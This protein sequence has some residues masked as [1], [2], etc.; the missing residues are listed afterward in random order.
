MEYSLYVEGLSK[1][2]QTFKLDN[3]SFKLPKGSIMGFVGENGSGKTTT[4]KLILNMLKKESGD[5]CVFGNDHIREKTEIKKNIG[6]ILADGF[7]PDALTL[8]QICK[9]M[10]SLYTDFD[11]EKFD[12]YVREFK[13]S[14][15][16]SI[17]EFST[18]MKMKAKL[19]IV[20]SYDPKL[21]ILDEPTNGLD[22]VARAEV[23]DI[24]MEYIQDEEKSI[25]LSSHIT[26]DLEKIAD[27][28][29]F[30]HDGKIVFS[31]SREFL[32]DYY[33]ILKCAKSELE[34]IDR[35]D[36]ISKRVNRFGYELLIK[37]RQKIRD[38]YPEK[39][40]DPC[41]YRRYY[42]LLR[43]RRKVM[44]G[45]LLKEFY[46]LRSYMKTVGT[47]ILFVSVI[48]FFS[49]DMS[50]T[51][52]ITVVWITMISVTTFSIDHNVG[53]NQ[54]S[55]TLPISTNII[56]LSKYVLSAIL[57]GLGG[58]ISILLNV[59]I[60]IIR[61]GYISIEMFYA[62][63]GICAVALLMIAVLLPLIYKYGVE[64]VRIMMLFVFVIPFGIFMLLSWLNVPLPSKETISLLLK[65]SPVF[66]LACL[67]ISY[68]ISCGIFQRK[69]F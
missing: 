39:I 65:L 21:L 58:M 51:S 8:P 45:L 32:T 5:V 67:G 6:V 10:R 43:K 17:S 9:V 1:T 4:I 47:M 7:F 23:L 54:F 60:T 16:Q 15:Q 31:E 38:K 12:A 52:G 69:E 49:N 46:S 62:T 66:V 29:T 68:K 33:G 63:A 24:F 56:V 27:Y 35:E 64:K 19:A 40:I 36:I 57:V 18:G 13:L 59:L 22:P 25:F 37:D 48:A 30:I 41:I 11:Q 44:K 34:E 53:W 20:L 55:L 26:G 42:A 2:F 3:V 61:S 28:I 14:D 50:Y